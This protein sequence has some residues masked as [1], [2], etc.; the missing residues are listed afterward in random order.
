M[1]GIIEVEGARNFEMLKRWPVPLV[2]AFWAP[3]CQPCHAMEPVFRKIAAKYARKP[4][5]EAIFAKV[6]TDEHPELS[7]GVVCLPTFAVFWCG[8]LLG[9]TVGAKPLKE[10]D[11]ELSQLLSRKKEIINWNYPPE[12]MPREEL[13]RFWGKPRK[14]KSLNA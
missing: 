2:V 11:S 4:R 6:N 3:R 5:T 12:D 10:F 9:S 8:K 14:R 13:E 7:K 1:R